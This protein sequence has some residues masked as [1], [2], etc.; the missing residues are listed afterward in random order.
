MTTA[1]QGCHH[2]RRGRVNCNRDSSRASAPR[3]FARGSTRVPPSPDRTRR[4]LAEPS[5]D[6]A[7]SRR[8]DRSRRDPAPKNP[9]STRPNARRFRAGSRDRSQLRRSA[10]PRCPI[11]YLASARAHARRHLAGWFEP[12]GGRGCASGCMEKSPAPLH[13]AGASPASSGSRRAAE[14]S[15][16]FRS[17]TACTLKSYRRNRCSHGATSSS[18]CSASRYPRAAARSRDPR[19]FHS[20]VQPFGSRIKDSPT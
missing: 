13:L 3:R 15:L 8:R 12:T 11:R 6:R 10:V 9:T 17:L 7:W 1:R 19:R 14:H 16:R 20:R 2:P 4:A 5:G 18:R